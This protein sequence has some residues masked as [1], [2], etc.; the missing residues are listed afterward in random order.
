MRCDEPQPVRVTSPGR[1][2]LPAGLPDVGVVVVLRTDDPGRLDE[3]A[4]VLVDEGL[5]VMEVTMTVPGALDHVQRL[6]DRLSGSAT[7]G[8][9]TITT[10]TDATRAI[11]AG[12]Q[13]LVSPA[14]C[15]DVCSA[16][17]AHGVPCISGAFTA[18]ELLMGWRAGAS[19]VKLFPASLLRPEV[20]PALAAPFPD[21]PLVPTGGVGIA[22][23]AAWLRAGAVAVGI[24]SP[25]LGDALTG[26]GIEPLR[27]RAR[28]LRRQIEEA[29]DAAPVPMGDRTGR[30]R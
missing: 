23:V 20:V 10:A 22:D 16:A 25:L 2:P 30:G 26:G 17:A 19:A 21:V 24:G 5:P 8:A 11:D 6:R 7:V 29:R 27:H 15:A 3:V 9:G 18:T 14:A 12:A 28:E 1:A 13:L 4:D